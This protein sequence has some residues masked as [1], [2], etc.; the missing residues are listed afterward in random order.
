MVNTEELQEFQEI[1][2]KVYWV[3][4]SEEEATKYATSLLNFMKLAVHTNDFDYGGD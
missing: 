3:E 2:K 4:I 1:Y